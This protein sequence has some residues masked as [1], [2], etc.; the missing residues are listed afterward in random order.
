VLRRHPNQI[1][2]DSIPISRTSEELFN[3]DLGVEGH[4]GSNT[5]N[6]R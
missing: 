1:N 2:V 5:S 3:S 6:G 4:G